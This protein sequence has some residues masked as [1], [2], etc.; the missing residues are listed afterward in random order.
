MSI[1]SKLFGTKGEAK[2]AATAASEEYKGFRI[3]PE[4]VADGKSWRIAA[5]IDKEVNGE[6]KRHH[7]IRADTLV[8]RED[9]E[10][11]SVAKAK[12]MIDQ[13]G[14]RLFG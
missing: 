13:M 2:P 4:P 10:A 9:A 8:V 7:L 14:D 12:V 11:A 6:A 3:T 1:L 5:W